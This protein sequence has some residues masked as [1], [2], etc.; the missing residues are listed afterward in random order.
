MGIFDFGFVLFWNLD[1]RFF[2]FVDFFSGAQEGF[3]VS[4]VFHYL[5]PKSDIKN[6]HLFFG[7]P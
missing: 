6:I 5:N 4:D 1:F 2:A 3:A 7:L